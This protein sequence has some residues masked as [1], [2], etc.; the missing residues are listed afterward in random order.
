MTKLRRALFVPVAVLLAVICQLTLVN[1][2]PLP[3]GRGV[4]D[5][6]LLVVAALGVTIGPTTGMLAGFAGGLAIDVAPPGGHLAGEYALV[7]CLV[8]Y[9]CGRIRA[10]A[11][12]SSG[13]RSALIS[14]TVMAAGVAAG[15]AG[16]AAVGL[17]LSDPDMTGPAIRHVLPTALVYDLL[18][19][20]F[21]L[22]LV[23]LAVRAPVPE[24]APRPEFAR[25]APAFRAASAGAAPKLRLAG[26]TPPPV[27]APRRSEPRLRLAS[28]SSSSFSRTSP[29]FSPAHPA[30]NGGRPVKV[31]FTAAGRG[32]QLGG[33]SALRAPAGRPA[34]QPARGWLRGANGSVTVPAWTAKSP[35]KGWLRASDFVPAPAWAGS[36]PGN[37]WLRVGTPITPVTW[38]GKSPG[39]GWLRGAAFAP[40]PAWAGKS[41][42]RGWLRTGTPI[43][44][45]TWTGRSPGK[46]WLR[47]GRGAPMAGQPR[48]PKSPGK[49]WARAPR[50]APAPRRKSPGRG[51]L[52]QPKPSQAP[53]LRS[54]GRRWI[55][56]SKPAKANWYTASPSTGWLKRG[57]RRRRSKLG[58]RR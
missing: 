16:K 33:S 21:V 41:P 5:L 13:E 36:S 1:R 28:G 31:N 56:P 44:E 45:V 11:Q 50:P 57:R 49:G 51:W 8:G 4:P 7:Y 23:S 20:A 43:A 32:N 18:L 52:R 6:V 38:S 10:V 42:G 29:A 35:G 27:P 53:R 47:A 30:A 9:G 24:P 39:R 17:M 58:G 46:G 54:P 34:A 3:G 19:C 48:T 22:W 14:L 15:E 12:G 40:A 25:W 37:G 26:S 2:A 55:R